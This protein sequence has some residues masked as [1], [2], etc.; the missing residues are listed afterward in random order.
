MRLAR[1]REHLADAGAP[2]AAAGP[3]EGGP[4][5][6]DVAWNASSWFADPIPDRLRDEWAWA[7]TR[8]DSPALAAAVAALPA[9]ERRPRVAIVGF[10]LESNRFAPLVAE[11]DF[12][13]IDGDAIL[14]AALGLGRIVALY[15][16]SPTLY[17]IH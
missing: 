13:R 9:G 4:G 5:R 10:Q 11:A 3:E 17:Q 16:R 7:R 15:H 1:L 14:Q 12:S 6:G 2:A 8:V